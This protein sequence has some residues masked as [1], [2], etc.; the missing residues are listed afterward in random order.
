MA[1]IKKKII[2]LASVVL[3]LFFI[4]FLST[5]DKDCKIAVEKLKKMGINCT[6]YGTGIA[7]GENSTCELT[8]KWNLLGCGI[9]DGAN[10]WF[11]P[12][13]GGISLLD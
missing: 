3:L 13:W 12:F 10:N 1:I 4:G 11:L 2:I 7:A 5:R 8:G 9:N 6:K